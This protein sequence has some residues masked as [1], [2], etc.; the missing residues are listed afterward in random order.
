MDVVAK[1]FSLL[2]EERDYCCLR[3]EDKQDVSADSTDC[4]KRRKP[5]DL[6]NAGRRRVYVPVVVAAIF[7]QP[8]SCRRAD[9]VLVR[10]YR[11]AA[12][13]PELRDKHRTWSR[14]P[15]P[16]TPVRHRNH[17]RSDN[18]RRLVGIRGIV[19]DH[20]ARAE[21]RRESNRS[22]CA[23]RAKIVEVLHRDSGDK[24]RAD[25]PAPRGETAICGG[26][27]NRRAKYRRLAYL[28]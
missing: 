5:Y 17:R 7:R 24:V 13:R 18:R 10:R 19:S 14:Q 4:F 22:T 2:S 1:F 16:K 11:G 9:L 20:A 28:F 25:C 26:N 23:C 12:S 21:N 6:N 3:Q 27:L 15:E 8:V